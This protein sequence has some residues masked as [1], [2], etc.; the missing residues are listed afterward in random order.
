MK[1]EEL[2]EVLNI[3]EKALFALEDSTTYSEKQSIEKALDYIQDKMEELKET[4]DG[5]V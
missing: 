4:S 3:I 1:K 2:T 5:N